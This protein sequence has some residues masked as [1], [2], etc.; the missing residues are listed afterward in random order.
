M[1]CSIPVLVL[2]T[3]GIF[4]GIVALGYAFFYFLEHAPEK[5]VNIFFT[6][7]VGG[8]L[9]FVAFILAAEVCGVKP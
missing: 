2:L 5:V 8:L 4:A 3:L 9:L 1:T 6:V 7:L